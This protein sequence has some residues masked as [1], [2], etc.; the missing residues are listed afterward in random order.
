M[1]DESTTRA[2]QPPEGTRRNTATPAHTQQEKRDESEK[3]KHEASENDLPSTQEKNPIPPGTTRN[4][5]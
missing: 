1:G 3:S 4:T 2:D 5:S